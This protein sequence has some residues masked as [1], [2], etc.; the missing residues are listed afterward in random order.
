MSRPATSVICLATQ[1]PCPLPSLREEPQAPNRCQGPR[2]AQE[3]TRTRAG[4]TASP[5]P[6]TAGPGSHLPSPQGDSLLRMDP[7]GRSGTRPLDSARSL[8]PRHRHDRGPQP[9]FSAW[10][11]STPAPSGNTPHCGR[12]GGRT[13]SLGT[14]RVHGVCPFPR[15][16]RL[17]L[18]IL[19]KSTFHPTELPCVAHR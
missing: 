18:E 13:P 19:Q 14:A 11:Q 16:S 5:E 8:S 2:C 9:R 17:P 6:F 12:A 1:P 4:H 10:V 7:P 3:G 15:R